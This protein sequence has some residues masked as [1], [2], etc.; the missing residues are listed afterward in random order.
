MK[1]LA[2]LIALSAL[3]ISAAAVQAQNILSNGTLDATAVSQ[4]T[5]ATPVFWN[6]DA[7]R[8]VSGPFTDGASSEGFAGGA[9][10]PDTDFDPGPATTDFGL[11]FKPFQGNTTDGDITVNFTQDNPAAAGLIYSLTGW[12]G[13]GVNYSGIQPGT[14]TRTELAIDFLDGANSVI[15]GQSLDL[16]AAG[17]GGAVTF[18]YAPYSVSATAPAGTVAVRSRVSMIDAFGTSGQQ[19]FV[20]DDFSLTVVPEPGTL[21]LAAAGIVG[22]ALRRRRK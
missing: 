11:F 2:F 18:G 1:K 9:P 15:G 10:T 12:A 16:A 13:A 6:V 4:Q 17:L 7:F 5:L 3:S 8:S 22:L 19:A 14:R 21:A 20:V